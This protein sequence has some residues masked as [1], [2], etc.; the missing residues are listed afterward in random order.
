MALIKCKEC[1]KEISDKSKVCVNCG[2][3]TYEK[4]IV[5]K[6]NNFIFILGILICFLGILFPIQL[7]LN[8]IGISINLGITRIFIILIG[9]VLLALSFK[10]RKN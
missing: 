7:N 8:F 2:S 4:K 1:Q 3:A 5:N 10:K 9:V 6:N